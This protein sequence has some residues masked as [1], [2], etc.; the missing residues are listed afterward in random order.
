M[1]LA[2]E[3]IT[4]VGSK[5]K[6]GLI[7]NGRTSIQYGKIDQLENIG[8]HP[9]NDI[10]GTASIGIE[11]IWFKVEGLTAKPLHTIDTLGALLKLL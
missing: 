2:L 5:Y 6:I 11:T 4:H 9:V 1:N 8:D 3:V 7:T 10:E